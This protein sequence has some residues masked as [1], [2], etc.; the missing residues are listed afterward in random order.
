MCSAISLMG[1]SRT[2]ARMMT[3]RW[4]G[5]NRSR[6][7]SRRSN[8]SRRRIAWA[9]D[10]VDDRI[11]FFTR[12]GCSP[13]SDGESETSGTGVKVLSTVKQGTPQDPIRTLGIHIRGIPTPGND[14]WLVTATALAAA[15]VGVYISRKSPTTIDRKATV[16]ARKRQR[17]TLL[18]E[19]V[20]LERAHRAGDIGPK[21]YAR[22]RIKLVDAIADT[23][24]PDAPRAAAASE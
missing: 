22:E 20:E 19:L 21:A 13:E 1:S 9:G 17:K 3:S 10:V 16:A 12:P 5:L 15:L 7:D 8:R 24:D 18:A 6:E 23:L 2:L 11:R 14:R 4:S